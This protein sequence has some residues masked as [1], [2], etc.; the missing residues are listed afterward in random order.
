VVYAGVARELVALDLATGGVIWSRDP[1]GALNLLASHVSPAIS[2][3]TLILSFDRGQEGLI[4]FERGTGAELWR[5]DS[6][7]PQ[8]MHASP[9][10]A[11]GQ[12]YVINELTQVTALELQDGSRRWQRQLSDQT[13][14]WGYL[15][16]ATPAYHTGMLFVG[17]QQGHLFAL[18]AGTSNELW[19]FEGAPSLIRATH[20]H[21]EIA[22]FPAAPVITP[23]VVWVTSPDGLLRALDVGTGALLWSYDVGVPIMASPAAAGEVLFVASFDGTV[24]ALS[25]Q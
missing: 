12:V 25:A 17:T 22:A 4:A 3:N 18:D 1:I 15:S 24:R 21:G 9:V 13:F 11:D 5:T 19:R 23:G 8:H 10:I 6:F 20:Y 7:V 14:G 2:G 16:A